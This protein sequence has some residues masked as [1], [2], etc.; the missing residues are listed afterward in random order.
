[1]LPKQATDYNEPEYTDD[2]TKQKTEE[3]KAR[4]LAAHMD[5][6]S[7]YVKD[8]DIDTFLKDSMSLLQVAESVHVHHEVDAASSAFLEAQ[9][10]D[11]LDSHIK[12]LG[13][14]EKVVGKRV[15]TEMKTAT[16]R[17]PARPEQPPSDLPV[18]LRDAFIALASKYEKNFGEHFTGGPPASYIE[19]ASSVSND[20]T[21]GAKIEYKHVVYPEP[22]ILLPVPAHFLYGVLS[23][24][25]NR[26]HLLHQGLRV[27]VLSFFFETLFYNVF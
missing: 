27:S 24:E 14:D 2:P 25:F 9:L 4:E 26:Q 5:D 15:D 21:A 22:Q 13:K 11:D 10:V 3:E 23:S 16:K 19:S 8:E 12:N 17:L 18:H 7:E 6:V 1:M 20:E